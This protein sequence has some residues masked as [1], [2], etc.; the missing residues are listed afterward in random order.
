M[1][2]KRG[3]AAQTIKAS[4]CKATFTGE[5]SGKSKTKALATAKTVKLKTKAKVKSKTAARYAKIGQAGGAKIKVNKMP[6]D[7]PY[8]V[9]LKGVAKTPTQDETTEG[10]LELEGET[11]E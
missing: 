11:Q 6:K 2:V 3:G 7:L 8:K 10:T 4:S 1:K 5:K 9:S